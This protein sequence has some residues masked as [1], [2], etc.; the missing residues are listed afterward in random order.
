MEIPSVVEP[1]APFPRRRASLQPVGLP[2]GGTF[3]SSPLF[4]CSCAFSGCRRNAAD[5]KVR[6]NTC[7][8]SCHSLGHKSILAEQDV[9][10]LL[11]KLLQ[12]ISEHFSTRNKLLRIENCSEILKSQ[13]MNMLYPGC[14]NYEPVQTSL[15]ISLAIFSTSR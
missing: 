14:D 12:L 10:I 9:F 7:N 3:R 8:L 15:A 13:K 11:L 4:A 6:G 1:L 2:V 5:L